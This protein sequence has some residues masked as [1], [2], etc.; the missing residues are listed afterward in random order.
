MLICKQYR[1]LGPDSTQPKPPKTI[2][3]SRKG[4]LGLSVQVGKGRM[5]GRLWMGEAMTLME[6]LAV[7]GISCFHLGIPFSGHRFLGL[8]G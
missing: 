1:W 6:G 8:Q 4:C 7:P 3:S 5:K 2:Q